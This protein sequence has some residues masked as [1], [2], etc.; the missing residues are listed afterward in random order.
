MLY[1]IAVEE[2]LVGVLVAVTLVAVDIHVPVETP[3]TA[4]TLSPPLPLPPLSRHLLF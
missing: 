2:G 4:A 1:A 3:F